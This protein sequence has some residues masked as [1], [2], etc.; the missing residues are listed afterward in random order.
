MLSMVSLSPV[1]SA[2]LVAVSILSAVPTSAATVNG[3]RLAIDADQIVDW[4]GGTD[5]SGQ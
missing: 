5:R 4:R 3:R 2:V 1:C